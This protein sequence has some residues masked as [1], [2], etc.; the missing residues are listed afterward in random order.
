MRELTVDKEKGNKGFCVFR[1]D[2]ERDDLVLEEAHLPEGTRVP[3]L[4]LSAEQ[5][6]EV[7]STSEKMGDYRVTATPLKGAYGAS[8][9]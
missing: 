1:Y 6:A 7:K 3:V 8:H 2:A 5:M 4:N 9:S